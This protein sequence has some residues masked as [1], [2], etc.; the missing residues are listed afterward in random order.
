MLL[1][2]L[3]GSNENA[4]VVYIRVITEQPPE[5]ASGKFSK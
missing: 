4:A 1:L 5:G 2:Q 3:S